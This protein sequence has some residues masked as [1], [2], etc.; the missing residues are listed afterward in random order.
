MA[1]AHVRARLSAPNYK[2][3]IDANGHQLV[4][5]EPSELGGANAGPS[6]FALVLSGLSACTTIT[7]K[8]YADKKGWPL[9]GLEAELLLHPGEPRRRIERSVSVRGPLSEEQIARLREIA[10]R[11]PVTLALLQGFDID[12]TL[13]GA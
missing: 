10:E 12:T 13:A 7:L 11:T 1:G 9:E 3:A 5:D 6:P 2:V 8:M 4:A